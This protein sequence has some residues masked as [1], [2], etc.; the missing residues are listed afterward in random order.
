VSNVQP[1]ATV[2]VI[3][4]LGGPALALNVHAMGSLGGPIRAVVN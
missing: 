3:R 1:F 2:T 4:T